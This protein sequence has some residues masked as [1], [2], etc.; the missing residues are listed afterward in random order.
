MWRKGESPRMGDAGSPSR[1]GGCCHR[2]LIEILYLVGTYMF[3]SRVVRTGH[4]PLD[5]EPAPSPVTDPQLLAA[6]ADERGS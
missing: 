6:S 3:V 2:A 5:D 4:V 1:M